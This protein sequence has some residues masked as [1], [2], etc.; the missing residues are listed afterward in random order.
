MWRSLAACS[1]IITSTLAA[2][3]PAEDNFFW[4]DAAERAPQPGFTVEQAARDHLSA[5][6]ELYRTTPARLASAVITG[7]H[8]LHDGTAVIVTF[9][10]RIEGVRVFLDEVKV[11]MN[12]DRG[13]IAISGAL[14]PDTRPLGPF[15]LRPET[16]LASAFQHLAG[17][18]VPQ[19]AIS[20]R[21]LGEGGYTQW[22]LE[23]ARSVRTRPVY[24]SRPTGLVP[25]FYGELEFE[26]GWF[27]FV[28]SAMDGA[29]LFVK[30]LTVAHSFS[31]WAD[32]VTL[33][34]FPGPQG[35]TALP[36]PTGSP[37]GFIPSPV[38]QQLVTLEHAG[39]STGD[40]WLSAGANDTR[41]N[42]V[43]AYADL[44]WPSGYNAS[45]DLLGTTTSPGN[46]NWIYDFRVV[47]WA[48]PTQE[49]AAA[50]QL[51]YVTNFLHDWFYDDGFDEAAGN[52]QRQ[53]FSRGGL[54]Y[55]PLLAEAQDFSGRYNA[56]MSTPSDGQ[57]P[58]MQMYLFA[59]QFSAFPSRDG[60]IDNGI[61]AHEW[62]HFISNRLIGDGNGISSQ[63]S[64]GMGEGWAD[65]TAALMLTEATDATAPGSANWD[66]AW[67]LAGWAAE[68]MVGNA[69]YYGVR[70]YPLS[71]NFARNPLTFRHI[72]D[73]V[74]LPISP[75]AGGFGGYNSEVHNTG[76]VWAVM[77]WEC[78]VELL[79]DPRFTFDQAR[80]RMKRYLVAAYKATPLAPTFTEARD[81]LLAVVVANDPA[82]FVHFWDAF[83]RRGLGRGAVSPDRFD[84]DNSPLVESFSV[85]NEAQFVRVALDDSGQSCDGDGQLDRDEQGVLTVAIRNIGATPLSGT[86]LTVSSTT[87][88]VLFPSGGSF[89]VPTM[90]SFAVATL[91]I[92]VV[93]EGVVGQQTGAFALSLG[94][95]ALG[96]N[97]TTRTEAFLMNVDVAS[98]SSRTDTVEPPLTR[99]TSLADPALDTGSGFRRTKVTPTQHFWFGP[100]P[101]AT[102]DSW[103][104]SPSLQVGS[105]PLRV[106]FNHRYDFELSGMELRDG[107]VLELSTDDGMTWVDVGDSTVPGYGGTISNWQNQS[108]NPLRG[109]RAFTG[110]SVRY[111]AFTAETVDL[112]T[113][114]SNR[115]VRLRFRIGGDSGSSSQARG[116]ELDDLQF[117]GITNTP[118]DSLVSDANTC[119]N[120]IPVGMVGPDVEVPE[121]VRVTLIG[122]GSDPDGQ[123]VTL[124]W[125][126][127]SGPLGVLN[128]IAF[129]TPEV[130]TDTELTLELTVSDGIAVSAPVVQRMLVKNVNRAPT[131]SSPLSAEGNP[132]D[133]LTLKGTG[134]DSDGDPLTFEWTQLSGPS[135]VLEGAHTASVKLVLPDDSLRLQLVVRDASEASRP[136]V[137]SIL[138]HA[139]SVE[140]PMVKKPPG[141]GCSSGEGGF[142]G[143]CLL[144]LLR[145]GSPIRWR[146]AA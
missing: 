111:P 73:S 119:S 31:V 134:A 125:S 51:F 32:P 128:G 50:V 140:E 27:S 16:A 40:P 17:K 132:G 8:D 62:G 78:Y 39:L 69:Y 12:R 3:K 65:F 29:V 141:C 94:G 138:V 9:Q 77:L 59:G 113:T 115:A 67:S 57:S 35:P 118:F 98:A 68:G 21:R 20:S 10:Q 88:G 103:L 102:A 124:S 15:A 6:A 14:T 136:A 101:A 23:G 139:R 135:V 36:H 80:G 4:A 18:S 63:Q 117:T 127:V 79:R 93:L 92:P 130:T 66:G 90:A 83:A 1:L 34:P 123:L 91:T 5:H 96:P 100:S 26:R 30:N 71:T 7:V 25:A 84:V 109:R 105:G 108:T 75:P 129:T 42:N 82:D 43:E 33:V 54:G 60:S 76:E 41:G 89:A 72:G 24:F 37:N 120:R 85:G 13:L 114:Y 145:R 144:A 22:D 38:P 126:Q 106:T 28:V 107:A 99:W 48:T 95:P 81:G 64:Y 137:T 56:D 44:G 74:V 146:R 49:R 11:I 47:P 110:R 53:N 143:W 70:R 2:A 45:T 112:G 87:A 133:E 61:V 86:R 19:A 55:D 104:L 131:A 122:S 121:G 46:F 116:W 142:I 58:R 52:G 97:P